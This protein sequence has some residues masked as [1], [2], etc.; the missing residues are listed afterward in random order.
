MQRLSAEWLHAG[1]FVALCCAN[2]RGPK[3]LASINPKFLLLFFA[4]KPH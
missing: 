4:L 3:V 1:C 2:R